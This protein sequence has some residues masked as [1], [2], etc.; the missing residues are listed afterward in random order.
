MVLPNPEGTIIRTGSSANKYAKPFCRYGV[1]PDF[2][3]LFM[4]DVG[5]MGIKTKASL[6][7]YPNPPYRI[8]RNYMLLKNDYDL[9]FQVMNK[10]QNEIRDGL[11]DLYVAPLTVM[12]LLSSQA[13]KKPEK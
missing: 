7:L 9:L 11:Q 12:R 1:S 5:T 3:G 6:K 4:G 10:C 2:T 13:I 8:R